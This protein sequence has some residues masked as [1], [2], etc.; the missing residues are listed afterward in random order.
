MHEG[1]FAGEISQGGLNLFFSFYSRLSGGY[2][3]KTPS[4]K[5]GEAGYTKRPPVFLWSGGSC[6]NTILLTISLM[7]FLYGHQILDLMVSVI[8]RVDCMLNSTIGSDTKLLS[9]E[10]YSLYG[11]SIQ[12]VRS[13]RPQ[14]HLVQHN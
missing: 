13:Y 2:T 4:F 14:N 6:L 8:M 1:C 3:N 10:E 9:Y 5:V 12:K 7:D 11:V